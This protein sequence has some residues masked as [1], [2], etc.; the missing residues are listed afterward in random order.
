LKG[1]IL[2]NKF[3]A[4]SAHWPFGIWGGPQKTQ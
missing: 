1:D 4:W 3:V 2:H